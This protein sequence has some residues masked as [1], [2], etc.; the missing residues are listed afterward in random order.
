MPIFEVKTA[1]GKVFEVNAPDANAAAQALQSVTD[2]PRRAAGMTREQMVEQYRATKPGD[3][4]GDFLAN[5]IQRP[6]KGET[7]AQAKVRAGGTGTTDRVDMSPTGK[8]AATFLQGVPFAGEYMDE[9]LGWLAGKMGLQDQQT[10]T[11][12]IRGGQADLEDS[13]PKTATALKI[14]GG[15]AGSAV[16]AGI[17]PWYMPQSIGAQALYGGGVGGLLGAAEGAVSGYGSGTDDE[18][19]ASNAG[20]R[21][22][23]GGGLGVV[24]GAA[25]P[26]LASGL[27]QGARWV[28]D[29]FN[30]ARNAKSAGL[31]RPSYELL[32]RAM[33]AD[34]SLTGPGSQR[35]AAAGSEGM[36]ANAGPNAQTLLDVVAQKSGPAANLVRD[37]LE[38]RATRAGAQINDALDNT[39]GVPRGMDTMETGIRK[40]SAASRKSTYDAAYATPVN[41]ADPRG[42]A[43]EDLLSR[44][45]GDIIGKAN[46]LMQLGGERSQQ[47]MA[48]IAPD[49]TVT[50]QQLPDVR[51]LDYIT[52]ALNFAAESGEGAGALGGQTAIGRAY[53]NLSRDIRSSVRDLVPQYGTA[54]DTAAEPIAAR[55]ALQFGERLFSPSV[56][57][58]E[59][60][61]SF[62]SMSKA[63]KAQ[64]AAGLRSYIDERLSNVTRALTDNNMDAREAIKAV[65]EL[66][67]RA[68]REKVTALIGQQ[69]ADTLFKQI[70]QAAKSLELRANVATNSKTFVRTDTDNAIQEATSGGILGKVRSGEPLNTG[71]ELLR[72]LLG[73][74]DADNLA[75]SDKVY[76]EMANAL[77]GPNPQQILRD[78]QAIA[79]A[80]P[81]NKAVAQAVG[82]LIGYPVFAPA[83]YQAG[84]QS[85]LGTER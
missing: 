1:D 71:K 33:E 60:A 66:S 85:L 35:I 22:L 49:G 50:Y 46:R 36:L 48:K 21:S 55:Q 82:R 58:D 78:L 73:G 34:G 15:L 37:R 12:A 75:R 69:E 31:S 14:G 2:F 83:A 5:Q 8:A 18:S 56:T 70:D 79:A 54:L 23:I 28:L 67:S 63:E 4:W 61:I 38:G 7:A 24:T 41:Y 52:R 32:N 53:Q 17:A 40:G 47:I 13:N 25:A 84:T 42:Q 11:D 27:G 29:R 68:N 59:A 64:A 43:L 16:G 77:T 19:R 76:M 10:A 39:L 44:I 9:K 45:P 6:M 20:Q 51:Q 81:R 62:K 30:V 74:T 72:T 57:R 3:M 26:L 80:N 65:K